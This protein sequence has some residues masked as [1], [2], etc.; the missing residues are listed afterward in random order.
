MGSHVPWIYALSWQR[1]SRG[2]ATR[3]QWR[4]IGTS[5]FLSRSS[6]WPH[7]P[8]LAS[9]PRREAKFQNHYWTCGILL[10]G[11]YYH[12]YYFKGKVLVVVLKS[13]DSPSFELKNTMHIV[14]YYLSCRLENLAA[15]PPVLY[16]PS[17]LFFSLPLNW[18]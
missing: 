16:D 18:L 8:M 14:W 9:Y 6:L 2:Y 7:V 4:S 1:Q 11:N 15:R 12:Y 13:T 10:T 17:A 3:Y 5:K